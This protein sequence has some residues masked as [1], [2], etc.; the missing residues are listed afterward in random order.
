MNFSNHGEDAM[1]RPPAVVTT[2]GK[3]KQHYEEPDWFPTTPHRKQ[4]QQQY[5]FQQQ[6]QYHNPR[7]ESRENHWSAGTNLG[8]ANSI[9][10]DERDT[11]VPVN[12]F[13]YQQRPMAMGR[14]GTASQR[15]GVQYQQ[16]QQQQQQQISSREVASYMA[17]IKAVSDSMNSDGR[18]SVTALRGLWKVFDAAMAELSTELNDS[19]SNKA[20]FEGKLYTSTEYLST[21]IVH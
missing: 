11:R 2:M 7:A 3:I 21:T 4:H 5:Q 15:P 14:G 8:V 20:I 13:S 16:L 12:N 18:G 9:I 6:Q 10:A 19:L 17:A 1:A